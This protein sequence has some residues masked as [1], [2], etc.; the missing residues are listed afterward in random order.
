MIH[1]H[2]FFTGVQLVSAIAII[3]FVIFYFVVRKDLKDMQK[4]EL[5]VLFG[6]PALPPQGRQNNSRTG[7]LRA[8]AI[9]ASNLREGAFRPCSICPM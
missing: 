3:T 5:L 7:T 4:K 2:E 6:L 8:L 9:A 1:L